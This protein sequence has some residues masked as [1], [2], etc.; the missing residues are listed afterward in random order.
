[1]KPIPEAPTAPPPS[2]PPKPPADKD[3]S[4]PEPREPI[5]DPEKNK[6]APVRDPGTDHPKT[7]VVE[8]KETQ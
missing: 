7:W 3:P 2:E 1:M 4:N 6:V 5:I 8:K